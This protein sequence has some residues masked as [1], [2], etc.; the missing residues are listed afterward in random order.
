MPGCEHAP[1]DRHARLDGEVAEALVVLANAVGVRPRPF[2]GDLE[3][4][5]PVSPIACTIAR[6]SSQLATR[7]ATGR[8]S[9]V[10]WLGERDVVKP[11]AP[12]CTA[13]RTMTCI[14]ARLV[15]GGGFREGPLAHHVRA[16][17]RVP[18]VAGVVDALR[19]RVE[20]IEVLGVGLPAP[21][22]A[23]QH[24]LAGDVLRAFEV[25]EDQVRFLLAAGRQRESAVAHDDAR[26]AV[27][28]GAGADRVPEHL[29]VHVRVPVDE[30]GCHDVPFGVDVVRAALP[31]AADGGDPA[32]RDAE[33]RA[34]GGRTGPIDDRTVPD[35]EVVGHGR[36]SGCGKARGYHAVI[37]QP[38]APPVAD[39]DWTRSISTR[40]AVDPMGVAWYCAYL[41]SSAARTAGCNGTTVAVPS[42]RSHRRRDQ[43]SRTRRS[44]R[45]PPGWPRC[46]VCAAACV[47]S[48]AC[49]R[50]G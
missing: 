6:T 21:A 28:A 18:D 44:V 22:D 50:W 29:G 11:I 41:S 47:R 26:H 36:S 40:I 15:L 8:W 43:S 30:A 24:R 10:W 13:S 1:G 45:R 12:A 27:V 19:Q 34:I 2:P 46:S 35:D 9:E 14:R 5:A 16:Q 17:G 42:A 20:H 38:Y 31:D 25:P 23:L 7:L 39:Q 3:H 33:V 4:A 48:S 37:A 49:R 32:V